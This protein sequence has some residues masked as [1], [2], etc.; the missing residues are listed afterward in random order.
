MREDYTLEK[1][2]FLELAKKSYNSGIYTFTDFLGL[3]EQSAFF[4]LQR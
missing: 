1:K 2:R 3:G 4:E